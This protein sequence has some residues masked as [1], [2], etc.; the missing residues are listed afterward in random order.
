MTKASIR[1]VLVAG[2]FVFNILSGSAQQVDYSKS[3]EQI[4]LTVQKQ[5]IRPRAIDD[6]YSKLVFDG[7]IEVL[8][9]YGLVFTDTDIE[10]LT[11]FE[12]SIDDEIETGNLKFPQKLIEAFDLRINSLKDELTRIDEEVLD[13]EVIDSLST[14]GKIEYLSDENRIRQWSKWIKFQVLTDLYEGKDSVD[15]SS[16]FS[17]SVVETAKHAVISRERCRMN[18]SGPEE[19]SS[20]YEII[21]KVFL[22]AIASAFDPHTAYLSATDQQEFAAM[23]SSETK[24]FGFGIALGASGKMEVSHVFPGSPAWNSNQM[25]EGDVLLKIT[26]PGK[27]DLT[28]NCVGVRVVAEYLNDPQVNEAELKL[29]KKGGKLVSVLLKKEM[30]DLEENG[31]QSFILQGEKEETS[32]GYIYLPTFYSNDNEMSLLPNGCANDVA[33]ELIKLDRQGI[34]GLILDLRGNTGGSMLE[35]MRLSGLFV[36]YGAIGISNTKW[37]EPE[38]LKDMDRGVVSTKPLV[39]LVNELSASASEL[40]SACMQDHNRGLIVG[41]R[42]YGKSTMQQ[43]F[44][45]VSSSTAQE[46]L[47]LTIGEFY[48]VTGES[49]Q[50]LGVTPD[51]VLPGYYDRSEVGEETEPSSLSSEKI[52]KKTYYWPKSPMA[53][54]ALKAKSAQR[55]SANAAFEEV[56]PTKTEEQASS[57]PL[58]MSGFIQYIQSFDEPIDTSAAEMKA[59]Y[60]V[61]VPAYKAEQTMITEEETEENPLENFIKEDIFLNEAY[62]ITIDLIN[63]N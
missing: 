42:T 52:E 41:S 17:E 60:E 45:L 3:V 63:T 13:I 32:I 57:I 58:N 23:V 14:G 49:L 1:F 40:F 27:N 37:D 55:V 21:W 43:V 28:L 12:S 22:K 26:S 53:I 61:V 18:F 47:K 8:D 44:P 6:S 51:I 25:N 31:I 9:P 20:S 50:Q 54:E 36:D 7:T 24:S 15:Q 33:K 39:V 46:F 2:V 48:R 35:A 16:S 34:N 11:K 59:V 38:T 29:K 19:K 56:S 5:H 30:V 4:M 10:E 62:L